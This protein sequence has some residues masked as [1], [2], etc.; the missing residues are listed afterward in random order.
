[1]AFH[2][3]RRPR[4]EEKVPIEPAPSPQLCRSGRQR[5]HRQIPQLPVEPDIAPDAADRPS[6]GQPTAGRAPGE[7][8]SEQ[9]FLAPVV[10]PPEIIAHVLC[11]SAAEELHWL[12][13][14]QRRVRKAERQRPLGEGELLILEQLPYREEIG[15]PHSD[16]K[17]LRSP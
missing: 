14:A 16:L 6:T 7:A 15:C 8:P 17:P 10:H 4:K 12:H 9:V 5:L 2:S 1:M 3:I 13:P 11:T